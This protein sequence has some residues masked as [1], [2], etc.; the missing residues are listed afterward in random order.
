MIW[1]EKKAFQKVI[2][3]T[4]KIA[5]SSKNVARRRAEDRK[6]LRAGKVKVLFFY[7]IRCISFGIALFFIAVYL[8]RRGK[9]VLSY[10]Q[11]L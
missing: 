3:V 9:C 5:F 1:K 10:V 6:M 8:T 7:D 4:M 11:K 2:T